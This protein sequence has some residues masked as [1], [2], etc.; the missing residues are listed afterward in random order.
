M[1][2][3]PVLLLFRPISDFDEPFWVIFAISVGCEVKSTAG[4]VSDGDEM[5]EERVKQV[6][7]DDGP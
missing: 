3:R 4:N 1:R 7:M 5:Y 2:W 6:D